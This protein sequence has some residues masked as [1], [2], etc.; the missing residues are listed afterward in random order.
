MKRIGAWIFAVATVAAILVSMAWAQESKMKN[1]KVLTGLTDQQVNAEMQGWAKALGVKCSHC[2]T[3]GDFASDENPKK[4]LARTMAT[5]VRTINKDF[6][7]GE[8]KA[9]CVLCH[10]GNAVPTEESG[11]N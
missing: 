7:K 4:A 5:M 11:A 8:K 1:L 10:R 2:H 3:L 6:L 9:S